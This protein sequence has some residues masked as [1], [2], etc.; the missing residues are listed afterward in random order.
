MRRL[1]R[2]AA[3]IPTLL[4][5]VAFPAGPATGT[6]SVDWPQLGLDPAHTGFNP[7]ETIL[8]PSSVSGLVVKWQAH[9]G[10]SHQ[11]SP[12]VSGGL[13]LETSFENG[14][15]SAFD[16]TTG[17]LV[18]RFGIG[19]GK[20]VN[21]PAAAG[22]HVFVTSQESAFLYA[23][24]EATG[25]LVWKFPLENSSG[26]G[27]AVVEGS[28]TTVYAPGGGAIY[29]V[30]GADGSLLWTQR[31]FEPYAIQATPAVSEGV[32]YVADDGPVLHA[33]DATTGAELWSTPLGSG[34][35]AAP[36]DA[37]VDAGRVF[38]ARSGGRLYA[39]DASAGTILWK[40][41]VN[42]DSQPSVAGGVVYITERPFGQIRLVALDEETGAERWEAALGST[43]VY[44]FTGGASIANGVVYTTSL[45]GVAMAF[46]AASGAQLWRTDTPVGS[47]DMPAVVDGVVYVAAGGQL[48]AFGL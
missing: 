36:S 47:V 11:S 9:L 14:S 41:Q 48:A 21:T 18:W 13:V 38:V 39:L 44:S 45:A 46:D 15:L 42:A 6:S 12:I 3:I 30:D 25:S 8:G 7:A 22:G 10:G 43:Y 2:L 5:L 32:V 28:S 24:D 26:A 31:P 17:A 29:A 19:P 35:T 33:Y 34:S 20:L 16:I 1:P 4:A 23:L 40:R 27:P 37:T